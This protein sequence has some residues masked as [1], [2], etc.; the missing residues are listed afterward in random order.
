MNMT[1]SKQGN[2]AIELLQNNG[3]EAYY[4][5]GCVRDYLME[6]QPS[7][8]DITTSAEP[9]ETIRVFKD[10]KVIE[11]GLKHGTVTV[12]IN[13]LPLEITTFR[14]DGDYS[15]NRRPDN[16]N[17]TKSLKLDLARRDFTMN[18]IAYNPQSG[19]VDYFGGENDIQ[20]KVVCC[21]GNAKER[22]GED[23]LRILRAVRF[24]SQLGFEIE[25]ETRKALLTQKEL[26]KNI[27]AER[28]STELQKLLL[29]ENIKEVFM[30]YADIIG[31]V[32]PEILPMRGFEQRTPYHIYD[33]L[34]HSIVAVQNIDNIPY[35]KVAALLHDI[36]KPQTFSKDEN[37]IGHFY[38]HAEIS[39]K[40][41]DVILS[42]L[43]LDNFTKQRV[44]TLIKYH[45]AP[46][47]PNEKAV[48]RWL[49]KLTPEV[50]FELLELKR[51]DILAQSL[52]YLDRQQTISKVTEIANKIIAQGECFSL[53]DLKINGNDLIALGI[54]KGKEI[55]ET[56]NKL[57]ELVIDNKL[58]NNYQSLTD[59][60]KLY[61]I[62]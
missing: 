41:A 27:S 42:R 7:D 12:I 4:V 21:V 60:V 22:F 10:Y 52:A 50:F 38:G 6:K 1:I 18:A 51:A 46:I 48:K 45:N 19:F 16:V 43:K 44:T 36:G 33:I 57:L 56:L 62:S 61:I 54:P 11:T 3:Y 49:N 35:L 20:N 34:I 14:I 31:A 28:V 17:F 29:G 25:R 8:I 39:M 55:G 30:Q 23:S 40:L 9:Q 53:K 37:G 47:E 24:S 26:L 58:E 13:F 15:D 32:I 2:I 59:F 5:G